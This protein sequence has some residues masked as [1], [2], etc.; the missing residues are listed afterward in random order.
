MAERFEVDPADPTHAVTRITWA[1]HQ[2][3]GD[4]AIRTDA[5]AEMRS[6]PEALVFRATLCAWEGETLV[7]EREFN[8]SVPR[9]FI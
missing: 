7:F 1:Q 5:V 2:S 9:D 4:W 8:E 3:R 6:E